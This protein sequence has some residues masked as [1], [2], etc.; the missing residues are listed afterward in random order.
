MVN[1]MVIRG[2]DYVIRRYLLRFAL[3]DDML[4]PMDLT[5]CTVRSTWRPA[6]VS[7]EDD[8]N[9]AAADLAASI[10]FDGSGAVTESDG[11]ALPNGGS[12][13]AGVLELIADRSVTAALPVGTALKGDVQVTDSNGE[14]LTVL[15]QETITAQDAYTS[16]AP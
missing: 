10:T 14:V 13:V 1:R 4:A 16:T 11:L 3:V 9:D 8:P 5:G 12:A 7:P 2:D 15:V 6:P